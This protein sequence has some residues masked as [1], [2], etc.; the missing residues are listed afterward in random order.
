MC[1]AAFQSLLDQT[2]ALH[3]TAPALHGFCPFPDD[4]TAQPVTPRP[5]PPL[6]L[7]N[8]ETGLHSAHHA[9]LRDAFVTCGAH[10]HWRDTYAGTG[11]GRDFRDRFGCYCLIGHQGPFMS[12]RMWAWMVYLPAGLWYPWHQH[13]GEEM[14]HVIAGR[15]EFLR[16][17]AAPVTLGEGQSHAHA[18]NEPH[19]MRTRQDPVM[20]LVLWRSGLGIVPV[21]S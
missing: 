21:W 19:A 4:L 10:A 8:A 12:A 7:L 3:R 5:R 20:A 9:A 13:P 17:D 16:R 2:R 11:I 6:A 1:K 14:Y 18:A 15:A